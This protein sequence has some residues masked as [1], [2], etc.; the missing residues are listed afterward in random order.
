LRPKATVLVA[1]V[2]V[3]ENHGVPMPG[4]STPAANVEVALPLIAIL[5]VVVGARRPFEFSSKAWPNDEPP[6]DALMVM[7]EEP[8]ITGVAEKEIFVPATR[9]VV[10]PEYSPLSVPQ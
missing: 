8:R 6:P 1:V 2:D 9:V 3:A 7:G 10:A 4:A 5:F